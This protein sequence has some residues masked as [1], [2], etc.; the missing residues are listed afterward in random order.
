M[1]RPL[2]SGSKFTPEVRQAIIGLRRLGHTLKHAAK[3]G[4]VSDQ[5]LR[6]W[7]RLGEEHLS[8]DVESDFAEFSLAMD[9]AEAQGIALHL[10]KIAK[11]DDWRA[12]AWWLA[13]CFPADYGRQVETT[14]VVM[15][16][17][18]VGTA[19]EIPPEVENHPAVR[20]ALAAY[21][22]AVARVSRDS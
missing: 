13:R 1:A 3:G 18:A 12:S 8:G 19:T 17:G 14:P 5:T 6:T 21:A 9:L 22:D 4:G 2:G 11:S 16:A 10:G 7:L 20:E 15:P